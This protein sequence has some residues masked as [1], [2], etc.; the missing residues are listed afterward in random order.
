MRGFFFCT[1]TQE[2]LE[3]MMLTY[4]ERIYYPKPYTIIDKAELHAELRHILLSLVR[5]HKVVP[6]Y[7]SQIMKNDQIPKDLIQL[8]SLSM[9]FG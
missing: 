3:K 5:D 8:I 4:T 6:G 2:P 9:S 1:G 7:L